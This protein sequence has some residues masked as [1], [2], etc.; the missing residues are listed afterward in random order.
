MSV[1]IFWWLLFLLHSNDVVLNWELLLL[2]SEGIILITWN[3][4]ICFWFLLRDIA[5]TSTSWT[6]LLFIS[7]LI[8][9]LFLLNVLF[10][11]W[12]LSI[13]FWFYFDLLILI[14]WNFLIHVE[15]F[16]VYSKHCIWVILRWLDHLSL[17]LKD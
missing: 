6:W 7:L 2:I 8:Y 12:F 17:I 15:E 11:Q 4:H 14:F 16:W 5:R 9:K 3:L 10:F 13:D 1:F